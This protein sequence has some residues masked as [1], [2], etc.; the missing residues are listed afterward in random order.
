VALG[1]ATLGAAA[2]ARRRSA[3]AALGAAALD[4]G[5]TRLRRHWARRFRPPG[6][7]GSLKSQRSPLPGLSQ[8]QKRA[9]RIADNKKTPCKVNWANSLRCRSTLGVLLV[10]RPRGALF[11]SKDRMEAHPLG[12]RLS[13]PHREK[14]CES[15]LERGANTSILLFRGP[16][17]LKRIR[18]HR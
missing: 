15:L 16:I 12:F 4:A 11:Y 7:R 17:L 14:S 8:T 3:A 5:D 1:A 13:S 18:T 9:L 10:R 6:R 2:P